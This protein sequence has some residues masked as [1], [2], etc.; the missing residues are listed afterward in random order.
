M[1]QH[2]TATFSSFSE[3]NVKSAVTAGSYYCQSARPIKHKFGQMRRGWRK[4]SSNSFFGFLSVDEPLSKAAGSLIRWEQP[5]VVGLGQLSH[6]ETKVDGL[7][8]GEF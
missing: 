7:Y 6:K 5:A 3:K 8:L 4:S 1:F 2:Q